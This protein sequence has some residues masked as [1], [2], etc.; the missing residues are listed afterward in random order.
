[1]KAKQEVPKLYT[2]QKEL[3]IKKKK[4]GNKVYIFQ[5]GRL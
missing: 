3:L 1:M 4:N 5:K 2:D